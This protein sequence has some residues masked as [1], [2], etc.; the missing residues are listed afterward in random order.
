MDPNAK[1]N[2]K[3]NEE[4]S[5]VIDSNLKYKLQ[6]LDQSLILTRSVKLRNKNICFNFFILAFF[7]KYLKT[8]RIQ[9]GF[10]MIQFF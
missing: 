5:S 7:N 6:Q 9:S 8:L 10:K 3:K 4:P 1:E 2:K